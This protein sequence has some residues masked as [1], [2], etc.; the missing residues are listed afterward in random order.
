MAY[1]E[2]L[3][4]RVR[5]LLANRPDVTEQ[6]MFGGLTFMVAGHMC[7]GVQADHLILRLGPESAAE[8]LADRRARPMDFTGRALTGFVTVD[9]EALGGR[10]LARWVREA[11]AWADSLPPKQRKQRPR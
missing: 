5:A 9:R 10:A 8:A 6:R 2:K 3:A 4:A 1:D 7:C 11:V